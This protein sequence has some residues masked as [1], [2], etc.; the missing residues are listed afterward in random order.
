[1]K[2]VT[3][4]RLILLSLA[5]CCFGQPKTQPLAEV[6]VVAVFS[7]GNFTIEGFEIRSFKDGAGREWASS[8]VHGRASGIPM[9]IYRLR[10][11]ADAFEDAEVGIDVNANRTLIKLGLDWPG[12]E[13]DHA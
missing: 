8:F 6:T 13:N 2:S 3:I 1:M 11:Q 5:D 9:G 7:T 4:G 12:M 10:V